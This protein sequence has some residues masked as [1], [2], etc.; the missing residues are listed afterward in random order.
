MNEFVFFIKIFRSQNTLDFRVFNEF[1]SF[2]IRDTIRDINTQ[3]L[4]IR[5]FL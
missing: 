3:K 5:L 1:T 4:Q 2:K